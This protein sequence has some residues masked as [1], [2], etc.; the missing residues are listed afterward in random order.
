MPRFVQSRSRE[1]LRKTT[2]GNVLKQPANFSRST[3]PMAK[4]SW[5]LLSLGTRSGSTTRHSKFKQTLSAGKVMASVFWDRKGCEKF[6]EFMLAGTTINADC[7]CETLENL[8][9]LIQNKR[10]SMLTKEVHQENARPHTVRVITNIINKFK[11]NTVTH[12]YYSPDVAP[13]GYHLF[14]ELK[15]H[16]SGTHFRIR[17]ELKEEVLSFKSSSIKA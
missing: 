2:N 3:K 17:E 10:R 16:L 6:C 15:K 9:H 8:R 7:F 4:N 12:P 13:G 11:W 1:C 5:T 14:L